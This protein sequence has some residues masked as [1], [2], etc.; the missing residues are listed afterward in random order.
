M[1]NKLVKEN[2]VVYNKTIKRNTEQLNSIDKKHKLGLILFFLYFM[3]K[4]KSLM[5]EL[6]HE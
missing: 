2:L 5:S 4:Y 3:S 6:S 1:T